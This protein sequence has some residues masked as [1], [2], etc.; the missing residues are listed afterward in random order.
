MVPFESQ[1][2]CTSTYPDL[3]LQTHHHPLKSISFSLSFSLFGVVFVP[4]L[5]GAVDFPVCFSFAAAGFTFGFVVR[6]VQFSS[7]GL[8]LTLSFLL[9]LRLLSGFIHWLCVSDPLCF[10]VTHNC[11]FKSVSRLTFFLTASIGWRRKMWWTIMITEPLWSPKASPAVGFV[12]FQQ[13]LI[14]FTSLWKSTT[15]Y[16][17][18]IVPQYN[19]TMVQSTMV[20]LCHGIIVPW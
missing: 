18:R 9:L 1:S 16:H 5:V 8:W 13:V 20:Q 14:L 3:P 19:S 11:E 15:V 4:T 2:Q 10:I 12:A 17:G 6:L 7:W